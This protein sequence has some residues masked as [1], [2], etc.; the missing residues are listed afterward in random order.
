MR[1]RTAVSGLGIGAVL[2]LSGVSGPAQAAGPALDP[3]CT[4]GRTA[5]QAWGECTAAGDYKWYVDISCTQA[6]AGAST[7]VTGPGRANG[8]CSWGYV[9]SVTIEFV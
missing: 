7:T 5:T 6:G 2:V 8:Y 4:I 1:I 9:T 3:A